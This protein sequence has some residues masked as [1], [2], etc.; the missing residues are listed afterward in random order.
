MG[1]RELQRIEGGQRLAAHPERPAPVVSVIMAVF[2]GSATVEQA[3]NSVISQTYPHREFIV[4]DGGSTDG[5]LDILRKFDHVVDYWVSGHDSGVYDALNKGIDL[6]KGEWLY[7]LGSD[8]HLV[9][10]GVLERVFSTTHPGNMIYGNVYLGSERAVYDGKFTRHKLARKNICHQSAFYRKILF[11]KF[12][13]FD[14][15]YPLL[16]DYVFNMKCF[17]KGEDDPS[18]IDLII[19][20]YTGDGLSHR[21][22]DRNFERER[23]RIIWTN[24]GAV[25]FCSAMIDY[26]HGQFVTWFKSIK[27]SIRSAT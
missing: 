18:F 20:S 8:D 27:K 15:R 25:V 9:D 4:I 17:A 7:F 2:N 12:G 24:L 19:A 6:A 16:A 5:T 10:A 13:K 14:L 11:E 3:I 21:V 23:F 1:V 26:L 22:I